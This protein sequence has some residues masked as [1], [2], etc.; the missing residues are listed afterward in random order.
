MANDKILEVYL[1]NPFAARKKLWFRAM[2]IVQTRK[3]KYAQEA[4]QILD[5]YEAIELAGNRPKATKSVGTLMFEPHGRGYVSFG[6]ADGKCTVIIRKT[7]QHRTIDNNLV[8][9]VK[10]LEQVLTS[11]FRSIDEA[12][13]AAALEYA[14]RSGGIT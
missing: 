7:E 10:V 5:Q 1:K 4:A 14:K 13:D 6:Y 8:F 3:E 12:R 2:G 9:Q 11:Q